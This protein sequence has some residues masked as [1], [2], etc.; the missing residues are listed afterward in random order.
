MDGRSTPSSAQKGEPLTAKGL[1]EKHPRMG[2]YP[3]KYVAERTLR[4][5]RKVL[6]RPIKPEDELLLFEFFQTFSKETMR[7]RFFRAKKVVSHRMLARYCNV[8]YN[9]EMRI[10]AEL[11]EGDSRRIIG[12]AEIIRQ[13]DGESGEIAAVVGDPWWNLGLGA[14]LI[15][16]IVE[17]GWDTGFRRIFAEFLAENKRIIPILSAKGFE[18][19]SMDEETCVATLNL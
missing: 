14:M 13:A 9:Q 16:Y 17:I 3:S 2:T 10:V 19:S 5:G 11:T 1:G 18:F 15:D 4:D 12:M 7:L 6:L 8:D